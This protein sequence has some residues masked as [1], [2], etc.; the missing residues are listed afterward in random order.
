MVLTFVQLA[1]VEF[2]DDRICILG[3]VD[4]RVPEE[5]GIAA[6]SDMQ[7]FIQVARTLPGFFP[8]SLHVLLSH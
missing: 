5:A 4:Y 7:F 1:A 6:L 3:V 2:V 8:C